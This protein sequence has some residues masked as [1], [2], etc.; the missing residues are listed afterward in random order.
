M[1]NVVNL[2]SKSMEMDLA[3]AKV[4]PGPSPKDERATAVIRFLLRTA[5]VLA[6]IS[7]LLTLWDYALVS[8]RDLAPAAMATFILVFVPLLVLAAERFRA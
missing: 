2:H 7:G 4:A 5:A 8:G 3:E 1:T 6:V